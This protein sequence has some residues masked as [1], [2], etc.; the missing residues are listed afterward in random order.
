MSDAGTIQISLHNQHQTVPMSDD[1]WVPVTHNRLSKRFRN[2]LGV[3]A[4][5]GITIFLLALTLPT[6]LIN[7]KS[8]SFT[9]TTTTTTTTT[10][11][12]STSTTSTS[13]TTS[14]SSTSTSTTTSTTS[15][16]TTTTT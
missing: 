16:K 14:T 10:T 3:S 15:K 11:S 8:T 12:T 4:V 1:H 6:L 5:I 7:G 9:S 13:T 2:L